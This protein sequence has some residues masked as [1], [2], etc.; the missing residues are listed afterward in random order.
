MI[1]TKIAGVPETIGI[2]LD[3][4]EQELPWPPVIAFYGLNGIMR[5]Y[6]VY[7]KAWCKKNLLN[8]PKTS[9]HSNGLE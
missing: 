1:K 3:E 7:V 6:G 2:K 8:Q 4:E 9:A 5:F